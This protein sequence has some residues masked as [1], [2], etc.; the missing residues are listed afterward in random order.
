MRVCDPDRSILV[1]D[2]EEAIRSS[3]SRMLQQ[4]N[5][6]VEVAANPRDALDLLQ[7]SQYG[8]VLTDVKMSGGSGL[9][10]VQTIKQVS[11]KSLSIV[12]TGYGTIEMAVHAMRVGAFDFITKPY[13]I[14]RVLVAVKNGFECRRLQV[15]NESLRKAVRRQ[16]GAENLLGS[17]PAILEVQRLIGKVAN[18]D[19]TV[20]ILG[21]SGSGKELVACA[22]HYQNLTRTGPFV[23]VNCGAIP[24]NLLESELF[25]HERGAFTGAIATRAGR[26]ELAH[27]GTLFLDEVG[28]LSPALQVKLLRV[29]QQRSFE[30]VGGTKTITVDVRVIAATNR[31]LEQ[32]VED[33]RFREDLYYRLNVIPIVVPPLRAR[34][35]DIPFL[36]QYFL[37]RVNRDKGTAI[38]GLAPAVVDVLVRYRW[39][40]NVR[41]LENL[42]E[43]LAVLKKSGMIETEDLPTRILSP[44]DAV[45]PEQDIV[46]PAEGIDLPGILDE[47]ER[48]LIFKALDLSNGVKSR[49]A[50]LLGLNR[51]TLVEKMKKKAMMT[52]KS[53][54][55][56]PLSER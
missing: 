32:A 41:E 30:R 14:E 11:P 4:E 39:P 52:S 9:D 15:E 47:F 55:P 25:G 29:L 12:M 21:E 2:D 22:L 46:F 31:D 19:S 37:D 40:G 38:T 44:K 1:V 18:T 16:Y 48:Q 36:A 35:E 33:R 51:T 23:P 8:L 53:I 54:E 10:L 42:I 50:Q 26:F 56:A 7:A 27:K 17:S 13:E 3:L 6:H 45:L 43:R 49:A 28:E 34:V 20:L 5:Y 24:E